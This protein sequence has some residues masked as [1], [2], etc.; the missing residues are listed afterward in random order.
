MC[1]WACGCMLLIV[2]Q[3]LDKLRQRPSQCADAGTKA[4]GGGAVV[5]E[6]SKRVGK[7]RKSFKKGNGR[8]WWYV[9]PGLRADIWL[10]NQLLLRGSIDFSHFWVCSSSTESNASN[11]FLWAVVLCVQLLAGVF[12]SDVHCPFTPNTHETWFRLPPTCSPSLPSL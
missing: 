7:G 11:C 9:L 10:L 1:P 5:R 4:Q 8:T 6:L 12:H 3:V 2:C